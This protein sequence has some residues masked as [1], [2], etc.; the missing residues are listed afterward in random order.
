[1]RRCRDRT[2]LPALSQ[3]LLGIRQE[4]TVLVLLRQTLCVMPISSIESYNDF[5][6]RRKAALKAGKNIDREEISAQ[7]A[8]RRVFAER[9]RRNDRRMTKRTSKSDWR[10]DKIH[11]WGGVTVEFSVKNGLVADAAVWSDAM[12]AAAALL[13]A[14]S[15][16]VC[17]RRG[18]AATM[19]T[20][21]ARCC[22]G[23]TSEPP[24]AS[25]LNASR[26]L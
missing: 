15:A 26:F 6:E 13:S 9:P 5:Y 19:R 20:I 21:S 16:S 10:H 11:A 3:L 4:Y 12:A 8:H 18:S 23:R 1:M 24:A 17:S 22:A 2:P 14:R 25:L 7:N